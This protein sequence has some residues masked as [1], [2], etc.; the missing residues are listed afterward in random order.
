[1]KETAKDLQA[2]EELGTLTDVQFSESTP[3]V[4]PFAVSCIKL[5]VFPECR[6]TKPPFHGT[7]FSEANRIPSKSKDRVHIK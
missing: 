2:R 5:S 7:V 6:K 1:M 3:R 4:T